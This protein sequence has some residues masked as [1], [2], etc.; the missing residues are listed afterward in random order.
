[1]RPS[2]PSSLKTISLALLLPFACLGAAPD[3]SEV[4]RIFAKHCLECHSTKD[5]DGGLVMDA[6]A[7]LMKGGET[8]VAVIAGNSKDSLLIRAV[9]GRWEKGGKVKIMPPGKNAKLSPSE[10]DV[11]KNW[12]DAGALPPT[13]TAV[14]EIVA[15]KIT[16]KTPPARSIQSMAHHQGPPGLQRLALARHGEV[17]L[18]RLHSGVT[19]VLLTGHRGKVNAV[20]FAKD[21]K[22]LVSAG[23]QPGAAGELKI[24]KLPEGDLVHSIRAHRDALYCVDVSP[25][26]KTVATGSYDQDIKLWS[27]ETGTE[28]ATLRGHNG[29]V[30]DLAFRPDGK[31]LASASGD[32]TVKLWEIPS[33]KRL[34]TLS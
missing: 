6:H 25:D 8:G 33:G 16:P 21:G 34:D 22:H 3:Y 18:A 13:H 5:P 29:A 23:G 7:A 4:D 12:I 32:R 28:V 20:A 14:R 19:N 10:I 17:E 24:W 1:M 30:F 31:V 27:V 2:R 15:P 11:L 9:E 26:G